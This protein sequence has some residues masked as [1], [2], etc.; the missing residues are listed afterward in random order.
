MNWA[1]KGVEIAEP[2]SRISLATKRFNHQRERDQV[3]VI[4]LGAIAQA[5]QVPKK[6][7]VA[8]VTP[9]R[10]R[11]PERYRRP[12]IRGWGEREGDTTVGESLGLETRDL[13][14]VR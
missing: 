1:G 14:W 10:T 3:T 7:M 2:L 11:A 9:T 6:A 5:D 4:I 12:N 13:D 8:A